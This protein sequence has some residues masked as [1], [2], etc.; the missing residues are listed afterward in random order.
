M[1]L[2]CPAS[3][4]LHPF[5]SMIYS[6]C[7]SDLFNVQLK[8]FITYRIKPNLPQ[9]GVQGT[10]QASLEFLP[11]SSLETAA[12]ITTQ[13]N[14]QTATVPCIT[15]CLSPPQLCSG[16]PSPETPLRESSRNRECGCVN[17]LGALR[18][19]CIC[20]CL[21]S[22]LMEISFPA[23]LSL[24]ARKVFIYFLCVFTQ[25]SPSQ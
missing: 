21:I 24:P 20:V 16:S 19:P 17:L 14:T 7:T 15:C 10:P 11:N 8:T 22:H 2:S 5:A 13:Q 18:M 12:S 4:S 3:I 6:K 1:A 23:C 9:R 25:M